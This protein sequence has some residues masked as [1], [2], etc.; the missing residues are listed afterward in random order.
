[1]KTSGI[2]THFYTDIEEQLESTSGIAFTHSTNSI[3]TSILAKDFDA[4]VDFKYKLNDEGYFHIG[5]KFNAVRQKLAGS[6]T[7]TEAYGYSGSLTVTVTDKAMA[8]G[9]EEFAKELA[10]KEE[11][12]AKAAEEAKKQQKADK[13]KKS[14]A[15][16]SS[17][18]SKSAV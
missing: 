11:K 16:E 13:D 15:G 7:T 5:D 1:M 4:I 12:N 8:E 10:E 14:S 6:N 3:S 17:Q 2:V 18:S 9:A